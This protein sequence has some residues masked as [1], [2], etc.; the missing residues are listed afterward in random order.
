MLDLEV[1]LDDPWNCLRGISFEFSV[2][3]EEGSKLDDTPTGSDRTGSVDSSDSSGVAEY[4]SR[5]ARV[6][7]NRV[8]RVTR[9]GIARV[10]SL[11]ALVHPIVRIVQLGGGQ[12]RGEEAEEQKPANGKHQTVLSLQVWDFSGGEKRR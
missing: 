5:V 11:I 2:D 12:G 3:L 6:A 1:S 7:S 10:V 4:A 9:H 8:A